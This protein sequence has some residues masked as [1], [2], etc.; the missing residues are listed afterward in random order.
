MRYHSKCII[1]F[2]VFP[3]LFTACNK[4]KEETVAPTNDNE[5]TTPDYSGNYSIVFVK[6]Y[7]NCWRDFSTPD[8]IWVWISGNEIRLDTNTHELEANDG[9]I[10]L[11]TGVAFLSYEASGEYCYGGS[12]YKSYA[13]SL[14][15]TSKSTF[16]G[17]S[18]T[19][20]YQEDKY[21]R[22]YLDYECE[23]KYSI[24]GNKKT[25]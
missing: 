8:E 12:Y 10:D 24:T 2:L 1:A 23:A 9:T 11:Q 19:F 25:D 7:G 22:D 21:C 15:F 20:W 18:G 4:D 16:I 5:E 6:E 17:F 3:L 14:S 13:Y